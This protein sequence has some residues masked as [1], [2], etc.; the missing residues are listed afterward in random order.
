MTQCLPQK[1]G[2]YP[3]QVLR[4]DRY[5]FWRRHA[6]GLCVCPPKWLSLLQRPNCST[7][8]H[9]LPNARC[10]FACC[11]LHCK[12]S[13]Y[14]YKSEVWLYTDNL[15]SQKP[16]QS[17][18][19]KAQKLTIRQRMSSERT[20]YKSVHSSVLIIFSYFPD[21]HHCPDVTSWRGGCQ[22]GVSNELDYWEFQTSNVI[23]MCQITG[24]NWSMLI[25]KRHQQIV[26]VL[27]VNQKFTMN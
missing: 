17:Y 5:C 18:S 16:R 22:L 6:V 3:S 8:L 10:G 12:F 4:M 25:T 9:R 2:H 19:K 27:T 13:C 24:S 26:S 11:A 23:K 20:V 1:T 15:N 21:N 14:K 7:V